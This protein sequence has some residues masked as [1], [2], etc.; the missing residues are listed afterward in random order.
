MLGNGPGRVVLAWLYWKRGLV[1]AV[2]AH[3]AA[4]IVLHVMAPAIAST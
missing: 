1:A 3:F 4:D 2:T